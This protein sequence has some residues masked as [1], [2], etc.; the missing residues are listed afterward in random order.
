MRLQ[1]FYSVSAAET[2]ARRSSVAVRV[3]ACRGRVGEVCLRRVAHNV[4]KSL[5]D[6]PGPRLSSVVRTQSSAGTF[7]LTQTR[8]LTWGQAMGA[9]TNLYARTTT[10]VYMRSS[11]VSWLRPVPLLA[12]AIS[13]WGC[14]R[15]RGRSAAARVPAE[16]G[17]VARQYLQCVTRNDT[18][19]AARLRALSLLSCAISLACGKSGAFTTACQQQIRDRQLA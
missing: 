17:E 18:Y 8:M 15:E 4:T 13:V 19:C 6:Y 5:T 16:A 10:R 3:I 12:L 7:Q 9:M 1:R 2:A 11:R 14:S